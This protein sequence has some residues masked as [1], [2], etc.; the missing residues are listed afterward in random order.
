MNLQIN[1][2][3]YKLQTEQEY[4]RILKDKIDKGIAT[5]EQ[6]SF[7]ERDGQPLIMGKEVWKSGRTRFDREIKKQPCYYCK[8][9]MRPHTEYEVNEHGEAIEITCHRMCYAK[10]N[11][12][13]P[14]EILEIDII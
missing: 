1:S 7:Y 14:A 10:S 12:F 6:R 4:M 2:G 3:G 5:E 8:K 13:K 11:G 9:M